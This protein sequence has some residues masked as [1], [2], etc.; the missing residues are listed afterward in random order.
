[1]DKKY[2]MFNDGRL[3]YIKE[4][5]TCDKCK[6]RGVAEVFI[7]DLDDK[8]MDCIKTNEVNDIVYIGGSLNDA[9]AGLMDYFQSK[10]AYKDF[11]INLYAEHELFK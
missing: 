2:I 4:I 5:C 7:N 3:G 1:M 9:V 10:I 8:Y 11:L 6:E